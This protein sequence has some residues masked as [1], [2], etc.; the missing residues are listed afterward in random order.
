M[1][2]RSENSQGCQIPQ[3]AQIQAQLRE[4]K[5]SWRGMLVKMASIN[6]EMDRAL[7][8]AK[9]GQMGSLELRRIARRIRPSIPQSA[10]DAVEQ[11]L[12]DYREGRLNQPY[13]NL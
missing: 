11:F 3:F 13:V 6:V 8:C 1:S 10:I 12:A 2:T 4:M 5:V 7:D 9:A